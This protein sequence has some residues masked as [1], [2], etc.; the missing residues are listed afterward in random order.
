MSL[1]GSDRRGGAR[2][3]AQPF[4]PC[5]VLV[6]LFHGGGASSRKVLLLE[7]KLQLA[8]MSSSLLFRDLGDVE[9]YAGLKSESLVERTTLV[10]KNKNL[11]PLRKVSELKEVI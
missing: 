5:R 2:L 6:P 1:D 11:D 9:I 3:F 7:R 8:L 10:L 4:S